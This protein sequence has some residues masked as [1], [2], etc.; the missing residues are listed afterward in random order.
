MAA[1]VDATHVDTTEVPDTDWHRLRIEVS[2]AGVMT[3]YYD[4]VLVATVAGAVTATV[5]LTPVVA[6]TGRTTTTKY[7]DLDY[8]LVSATRA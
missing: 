2:A 5:A 3:V 1:T 4:E 7:I 8:V 6:I